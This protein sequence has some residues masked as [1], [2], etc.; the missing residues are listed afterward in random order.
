[1]PVNKDTGKW[2]VLKNTQ[3]WDTLVWSEKLVKNLLKI[4]QK[5]VQGGSKFLTGSG[6][7]AFGTMPGISMHTEMEMLHRAGLTNRETIAAATTNFCKIYDWEHIGQIKEGSEA[8]ILV[9]SK[10]PLENLEYLDKI[11]FLVLDGKIINRAELLPDIN[12]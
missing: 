9:L 12:R 7:D 5:Y 1:M 10:N 8:D 6:T 4:E 11:D 3:E 2:S